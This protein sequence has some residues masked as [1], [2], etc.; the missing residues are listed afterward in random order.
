MSATWGIN[1]PFEVLLTSSIAELLAGALLVLMPT[2]WAAALPQVRMQNANSKVQSEKLNTF[3]F[4]MI[5]N[6]SFMYI[7]LRF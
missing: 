6:F 1:S 2:P 5:L 4:I 3:I 7:D